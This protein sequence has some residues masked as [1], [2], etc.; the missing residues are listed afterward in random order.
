MRLRATTP[1]SLF[2]SFHALLVAR[3][4]SIAFTLFNKP[5]GRNVVENLSFAIYAEFLR[6]IQPSWLTATALLGEPIGTDSAQ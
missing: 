1:S 2:P 6:A 3:P 4:W 5:S